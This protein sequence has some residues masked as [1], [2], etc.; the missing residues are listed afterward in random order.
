MESNKEKMIKSAIYKQEEIF[1]DLRLLFQKTEGEM[2]EEI[3]KK[4]IAMIKALC[5]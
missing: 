4:L 2:N 3:M 1:E 5:N